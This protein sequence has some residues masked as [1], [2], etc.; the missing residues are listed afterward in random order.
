MVSIT[1]EQ[2]KSI[3]ETQLSDDD[4]TPYITTADVVVEERLDN[5]GLSD[6]LLTQIKIFLAAHFLAITKERQLKGQKYGDASEFYQGM[7]KMD[8][9]AS[10]Y[11]Q[12]A[13]WLDPT[14]TLSQIGY[15]KA[16]FCVS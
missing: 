3:I 13:S 10:F 8:L 12:T 16:E 7:T 5:K 6:E 2:V 11:G 1:S 14:G 9:D 15:D 4:I